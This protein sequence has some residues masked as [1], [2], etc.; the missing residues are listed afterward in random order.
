MSCGYVRPYVHSF[1]HGTFVTCV[2]P[3][4]VCVQDRLGFGK[5]RVREGKGRESGRIEGNR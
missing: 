2:T 5:G 3:A 1:V 4:C